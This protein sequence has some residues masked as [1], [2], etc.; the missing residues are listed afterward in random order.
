MNDKIFIAPHID[1]VFKSIFGKEEEKRPLMSLLSSIL[2]LSLDSFEDLILLNTEL[3]PNHMDQKLSRLDIRIK[4]KDKTEIDVEV[5]VVEHLA[6]KERA[7]FYWSRMYG[8]ML[9]KGEN[10]GLLKKCILINIIYFNLFDTPNMHTKFQILETSNYEKFTDH[11]EIHVLELSKLNAYNRTIENELLVDWAEFL[12]LGNEDELMRLKDRTDLPEDVLKAIEE[13]ERIK[14]NPDLQME[15]LNKQMAIMDYIQRIDD[16]THKGESIGLAKGKAE[17]KAEGI[18][19]TTLDIA[20]KL[21]EQGLDIV[22][23]QTATGLDL[24]TINKL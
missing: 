8:N 22:L 9:N 1:V 16:A 10:Y 18:V 17:G 12:S 4:L 21:K 20:K 13:Y 23:I 14:D 3:L 7:L 2:D 24:D 15:A 11:L 6:Y 5:Q 19:E